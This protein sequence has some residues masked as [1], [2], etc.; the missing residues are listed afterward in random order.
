MFYVKADGLFPLDPP[1]DRITLQ[2]SRSTGKFTGS[3]DHP[4]RGRCRVSGVLLQQENLVRG[5][6]SGNG[7]SGGFRLIPR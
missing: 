3:F 7:I 6:F 1:D 5:S 4:T 2:F